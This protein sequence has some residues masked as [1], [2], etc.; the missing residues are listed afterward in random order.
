[1]TGDLQGYSFNDTTGWF[2]N[3]VGEPLT[4][5]SIPFFYPFPTHPWPDSVPNGTRPS[6]PP[7]WYPIII[8]RTNWIA[9]TRPS[10][11]AFERVK[12]LRRNS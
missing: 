9:K 6:T 11:C 3:Y 8:T 2:P 12:L 1:M 4:Y 7:S 5:P 10:K